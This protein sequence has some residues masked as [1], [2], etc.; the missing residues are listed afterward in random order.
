MRKKYFKDN[1][2]DKIGF[3]SKAQLEKDLDRLSV[4]QIAEKY[5]V[6][7]QT[8]RYW[9]KKFSLPIK[10]R[11]SQKRMNIKIRTIGLEK[12]QER[13]PFTVDKIYGKKKVKRRKFHDE[14]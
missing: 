9:A 6:T 12:T 11:F 5:G 10:H 3:K 7:H 13:R 1:F 4:A 2:Q 8:I 14:E